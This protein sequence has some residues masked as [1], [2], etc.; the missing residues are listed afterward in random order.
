MEGSATAS[1][2]HAL[3][4]ALW[5]CFAFFCAAVYSGSLRPVWIDETVQFVFGSYSRTAEAWQVLESSFRNINHGQTGAYYMADHWLLRI[6]GANSFALRLPSFLSAILLVFS[7]G[8]VARHLRFSATWQVVLALALLAYDELMFFTGD[9]RSYMPLAAASIGSLAFYTVPAAE[10]TSGFR[11]F[12]FLVVLFGVLFMPYFAIYWF[13]TALMGYAYVCSSA[14]KGW[15]FESFLRHCDPWIFVPLAPF[16]FAWGKLTWM[17]GM[18]SFGRDP[19][20]FIDRES[21]WVRLLADHAAFFGTHAVLA[22]AFLVGSALA[23]S[24]ASKHLRVAAMFP[25]ALLALAILISAGLSL[26]S[27]RSGYWILPRQWVG[28]MALSV[29]ALIWL[30]QSLHAFLRSRAETPAMLFWLTVAAFMTWQSA[31]VVVSRRADL[32]FFP[33]WV[34]GAKAPFDPAQGTVSVDTA[35]D[36]WVAMANQNI[37]AG[38]PVWPVFREFYPKP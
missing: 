35:N 6:F 5:L 14:N 21:L 27:W 29:V 24:F 25:L 1:S 8:M 30:M 2:K 7:A 31:Q 10:R 17:H 20:A 22:A 32:A 33:R 36:W 12:G 19:F 4:R 34:C 26:V 3:S 37:S 18:A 13:T 9:A 11:C 38:G 28:S 16:Y 15:A 23:F